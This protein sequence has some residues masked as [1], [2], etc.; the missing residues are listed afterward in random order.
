MSHS[1]IL[2]MIFLHTMRR[3]LSWSFW[4]RVEDW[5]KIFSYGVCFG[6][7]VQYFFQSSTHDQFTQNDHS[8]S[9]T[10]SD[11]SNVSQFESF[12][13]W[14]WRIYCLWSLRLPFIQNS[15]LSRL[16]TQMKLSFSFFICHIFLTS[17][18]DS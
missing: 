17:W 16:K 8:K 6:F 14:V 15:F 10:L 1:T 2:H 13:K 3:Q 12:Q 4:P 7:L 18:D 9:L 11:F 5:K